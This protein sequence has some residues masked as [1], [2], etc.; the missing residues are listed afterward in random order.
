VKD[1]ASSF[2]PAIHLRGERT[3]AS[4]LLPI[5]CEEWKKIGF[6][7]MRQES[8]RYAL[9]SRRY[10]ATVDAALRARSEKPRPSKRLQ[11]IL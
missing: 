10:G 8:S 5:A 4:R 11:A 6:Q 9:Q 2:S 7:F 3:I 1:L